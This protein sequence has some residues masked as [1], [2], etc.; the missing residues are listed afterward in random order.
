MPS[1]TQWLLSTINHTLVKHTID[2]VSHSHVTAKRQH[3]RRF[4][5]K[6]TSGLKEWNKQTRCLHA[7]IW[8]MLIAYFDSSKPRMQV[9]NQHLWDRTNFPKCMFEPW[10]CQPQIAP[11]AKLITCI[12]DCSGTAINPM[13]EITC[14]WGS[15]EAEVLIN[16]DGSGAFSFVCLHCLYH[17]K[18]SSDPLFIYL[19]SVIHC[20][21]SLR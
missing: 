6:D 3:A 7:E 16:S 9:K 14:S 21:K 15:L 11:Q 1:S 5:L 12:K 17:Q 20:S 8:V 4:I 13:M 18:R 19:F 2:F 10:Y